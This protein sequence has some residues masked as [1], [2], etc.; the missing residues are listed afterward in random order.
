MNRPRYLAAVLLVASSKVASTDPIG[1]AI[2]PGSAG[3]VPMG[4]CPRRSPE[5]WFDANSILQAD[6]Y[7]PRVKL[8]AQH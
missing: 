2:R 6:R 7:E 1:T 3:G 4:Q 5:D 8:A